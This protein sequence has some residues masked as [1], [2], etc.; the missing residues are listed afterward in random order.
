VNSLEY[1]QKGL[2][3]LIKGRGADRND[4]YLERVAHCREMAMLRE[5]AVWWRKLHV[6]SQCRFTAR[7]LKRLGIFDTLV[8]QYFNN[9]ATSP[10]IEELSLGF[11]SSLG[12]HAD[13]VVRAVSQFEWAFHK[14]R[15]GS[16][17]R[18]EVYWDR[19][20]AKFLCALAGDGELPGLEDGVFYRMT[21]GGDIPGLFECVR[22]SE[23]AAVV[24]S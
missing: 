18:Y 4:P 22:E 8:L 1:H 2:L 23:L 17:D 14:L 11:L 3:N 10:Y 12:T 20:P 16:G 7:L 15:A 21:I 9:N 6:G 5:I 19:H 24:A 13:A